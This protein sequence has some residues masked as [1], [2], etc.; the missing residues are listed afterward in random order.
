MLITRSNEASEVPYRL[1]HGQLA[2][3][4]LRQYQCENMLT[5]LEM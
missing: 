5:L 4:G 1:R 3:A 2:A